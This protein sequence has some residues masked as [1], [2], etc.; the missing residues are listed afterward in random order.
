MK[1]AHVVAAATVAGLAGV[2]SFH[3]RSAPLGLGIP[4]A[5]AAWGHLDERPDLEGWRLGWPESAGAHHVKPAGPVDHTHGDK[6][7]HRGRRQL[8]LRGPVRRRHCLR[9]EAHQRN[10]R[11]DRRGG[12]F[13][14]PVDRPAG[15]PHP[16]TG[17]PAGSERQYPGRVR[18][19]LH[20][21]WVSTSLCNPPSPS[22]VSGDAGAAHHDRWPTGRLAVPSP[23]RSNGHRRDH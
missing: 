4:P 3:T 21:H 9:D 5:A 14:F 15:H 7:S 22:W 13:P 6:D 17:S 19:E 11:L 12:Q 8:Q 16:R 23:R 2:L 1:R 18:G 10:D 20:E